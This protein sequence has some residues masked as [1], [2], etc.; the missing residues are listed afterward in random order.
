MSRLA[1]ARAGLVKRLGES[2]ESLASPA[3]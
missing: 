2:G 3:E 1:R